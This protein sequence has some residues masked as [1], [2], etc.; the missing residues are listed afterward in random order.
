MVNFLLTAVN[1]Y[2]CAH[3][4]GDIN[5]I[6]YSIDLASVVVDKDGVY[7]CYQNAANGFFLEIPWCTHGI[8]N[9]NCSPFGY[10]SA[11][12]ASELIPTT[13]AAASTPINIG[14]FTDFVPAILTSNPLTF[15]FKINYKSGD[16]CSD[17]VSLRQTAIQIQCG[18]VNSQLLTTTDNCAYNFTITTTDQSICASLNPGM[19]VYNAY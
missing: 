7:K 15:S 2:G 1:E 10:S 13:T 8:P 9:K 17:G 14:S 18:I 11:S 16:L 12:I 19:Y 5:S 6:P 3:S 4:M